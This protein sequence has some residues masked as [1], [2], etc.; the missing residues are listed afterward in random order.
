MSR[1]EQSSK[2]TRQHEE[3]PPPDHLLEVQTKGTLCR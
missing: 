3:G 2:R 1:K